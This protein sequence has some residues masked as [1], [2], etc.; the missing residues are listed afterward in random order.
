[1]A[2]LARMPGDPSTKRT[3]AQEE[4]ERRR[5]ATKNKSKQ[6]PASTYGTN[7]PSFLSAGNLASLAPGR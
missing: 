6:N 5:N 4:E 7:A 2:S 3:P 1:M